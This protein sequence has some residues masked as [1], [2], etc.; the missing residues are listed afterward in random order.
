[1][2][3]VGVDLGVRKAA[4]AQ[5]IVNARGHVSLWDVTSFFV[6]PTNRPHE[7]GTLAELVKNATVGANYV[8]IEEP[9]V[10]RGVK[11]SMQ[12]SQVA[13][14]IMAKMALEAIHT[15]LVNVKHWKK[16]VCGNGNAS[17]EDVDLWLST[18]HPSYADAC[19]DDRHRQDNVDACCI[20]LF[21]LAT[22]KRVDLLANPGPVSLIGPS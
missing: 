8:F 2:R 10:G 22:I 3:V 13:G 4:V 21:G 12:I 15:E 1:M 17:K 14:A 18:T 19:G 7:L 16:D 11:A 5:Y 9:L 20:G 6:H